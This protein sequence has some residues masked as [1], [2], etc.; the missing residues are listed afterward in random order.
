[1]SL[2][3]NKRIAASFYTLQL[4]IAES[5]KSEFFEEWAT[6]KNSRAAIEAA[7][8]YDAAVKEYECKAEVV[9]KELR[10]LFS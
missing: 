7:D 2:S 1:M 10:K 3:S 4:V 6:A 9:H 5:L 8:F